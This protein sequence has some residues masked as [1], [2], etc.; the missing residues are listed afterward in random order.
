MAAPW[1]KLHIAAWCKKMLP[2]KTIKVAG[3]VWWNSSKLTLKN[4]GELWRRTQFSL[5]RTKS[6]WRW[7]SSLL[8]REYFRQLPFRPRCGFGAIRLNMNL[9]SV[10]LIRGSE[11]HGVRS[12]GRVQ[13]RVIRRRLLIIGGRLW[14]STPPDLFVYTWTANW[15]EN[16]A[17]QSLVRWELTPS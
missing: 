3:R 8:E 6:L 4:S 13:G 7:K 1:S 15:H 10:R 16:T 5:I 11:A 17:H 14:R 12:Q 2:A 9:W